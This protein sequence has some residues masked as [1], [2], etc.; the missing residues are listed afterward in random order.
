MHGFKAAHGGGDEAGAAA[1]ACVEQ[2]ARARSAED[3]E[4]ATLGLVYVTDPL[5][6][7]L[8]LIVD[9]LRAATGIGDW[10]GAVGTGV[11]GNGGGIGSGDASAAAEYHGRPGIAV[12][13]AAGRADD[14]RLFASTGERSALDDGIASWTRQRFPGFGIVHADPRSG[15]SFQMV[16]TCARESGSF[17][18]GALSAAPTLSAAEPAGSRRARRSPSPD[19]VAGKPVG[20]G[21]SGVLFAGALEAA[22][23]LT[24]SCRPIG[25]ARKITSGEQN[26]VM[27]LDGRAAL[28]CLIEDVGPEVAKDL[29]QVGGRVFAAR[30]VEGSLGGDYL[31]RNLVAID[32]Q[33]GWIAIGD[34]VEEGESIMFCSRDR[35]SAEADMVRMLEDLKRRAGKPPRAGVYHSCTARGPHMFG[36]PDAEV[37]MI[38]AALGDFPLIGMFGNGEICQGRIYGYTGVLTLFL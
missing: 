36:R 11:I 2:L 23:G 32:Q 17:L 19:Q 8:P 28:D 6:P 21:V 5:A 14:Y 10:V 12:L 33:R 18:V 34:V 24:Q 1:R 35:P 30:P 3:G 13:T 37:Q 26:V 27:A 22:T 25:P 15:S 29:R 9:V 31:V 16:E 20:G 38:R 4:K 7:D